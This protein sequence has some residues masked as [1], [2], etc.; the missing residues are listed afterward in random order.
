MK[1]IVIYNIYVIYCT[2]ITLDYIIFDIIYYIIIVYHDIL[3][4]LF[5]ER[6]V[7][8]MLTNRTCLLI[9]VH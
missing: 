1:V 4:T 5:T 7:S 6:N 3:P 2:N 8:E 9:S